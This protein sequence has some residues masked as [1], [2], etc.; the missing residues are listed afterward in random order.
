ML[1]RV[2]QALKAFTPARYLK[3]SKYVG[4]GALIFDPDGRVLMI[5]NRLRAHWEYPAGG[6]DG[7]ESPLET[8]RREVHEE[9][10]ILIDTYNLI[11]VDF[12]YKLTPNGNLLFTFSTHVTADIARQIRPQELEVSDWRWVTRTEASQLTS[13]RLRPRLEQLFD[14][15]DTGVPIYLHTGEPVV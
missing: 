15:C 12:W 6:S 13:P 5:K 11:C 3:G 10:G 7:R 8:C 4:A 9:V 14:A 1:K 2:K